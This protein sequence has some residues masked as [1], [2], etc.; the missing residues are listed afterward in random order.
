M[1]KH[2]AAV[3][4][5]IYKLCTSAEWSA[6]ERTG[7]YAGSDDDRR[8]GFIHFSTR[9]QLAETARKYF[10]GRAGLVL[11]AFDPSH[12]GTALKWEPARGGD[13]FAHLYAPLPTSAALWVK[14][15]E[16]D[17]GGVPLLPEGVS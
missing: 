11:V 9:P 1:T 2:A 12:L 5:L 3:A 13:L 14:D 8:D 4:G 15:L 10:S 16:L 6:A 7:V 17:A